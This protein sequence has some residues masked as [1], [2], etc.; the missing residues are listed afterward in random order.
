VRMRA[1]MCVELRQRAENIQRPLRGIALQAQRAPTGH[2]TEA[3]MIPL[4]R[5]AKPVV[6]FG[7]TRACASQTCI[8]V[9]ITC[10]PDTQHTYTYTCM[11]THTHTHTPVY[12]HSLSPSHHTE[13]RPRP[14]W[15]SAELP[16]GAQRQQRFLRA[17]Q[18]Q[19]SA[20]TRRRLKRA[21]TGEGEC[22]PTASSASQNALPS[23]RDHALGAV[24]MEFA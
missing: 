8:G 16:C 13:T 15:T 4:N 3:S 18:V 5:F 20:Q 24:T 2:W 9:S 22:P 12:T 11:H 17:A 23:A 10:L 14:A 21:R 7:C 6:L 1:S 19:G